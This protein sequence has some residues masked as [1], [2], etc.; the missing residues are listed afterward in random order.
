MLIGAR[1]AGFDIVGNIEWRKYYHAKD[2]QGRNT[3]LENFPGAWMVEKIDQAPPLG[4]ID[5][6]MGHPECGS[7]SQL[8]PNKSAVH[9]AADIPLFVDIVSQIRP[10]FFVMDD[11]PK[12]FIAYPMLEYSTKLADYD[13]F[14]EWVSNYHYGNPQ[15]QRRR[16]FMIGA[17]KKEKFVFRPR[18]FKN[19]LTVKDVIG[20]LYKA[21]GTIPNHERHNN[22]ALCAKALHLDY[23][24]HRATWKEL[25]NYVNKN[26]PGTT[27][28]YHKSDGSTSTRIGTYKGHWDGPAHVMTGG[29]S[30]LHPKRGDPFSI[31]ERA[32]IQGFPDDFIFYGT[33]L[34]HKGQW[35]HDKNMHMVRQTGKAMPIQFNSYVARQISA[36]I[37]GK[38]FDIS[39]NTRL[40]TPDPFINQ[41]KVWYCKNIHYGE[42]QKQVCEACWMKFSCSMSLV[43][44]EDT[45]G[46]IKD[47]Q[48]SHAVRIIKKRKDNSP[49]KIIP[50]NELFPAPIKNW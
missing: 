35:E 33:I 34:N 47:E 26:R 19:L 38:Q 31:R 17:L 7:F 36:H 15:K 32:R 37:Q 10:R 39:N 27:I 21:E 20:D 4:G 48:I 9:N 40:L 11:L 30:A 24:G 29:L 28:H 2:E 49:R 3:F 6:V 18:E 43:S 45:I 16:M 25:A 13:L 22:N 1:Q 44:R 23:H 50:Y 41:A 12:S 42:N 8:N 46:S 5:L 14:P